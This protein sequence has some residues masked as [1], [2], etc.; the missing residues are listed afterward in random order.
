MRLSL[1]HI[2]T[3]DA[4]LNAGDNVTAWPPASTLNPLIVAARRISIVTGVPATSPLYG[5]NLKVA[6]VIP[7]VG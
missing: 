7:L 2:F 5:V 1:I 3:L 4:A 6:P